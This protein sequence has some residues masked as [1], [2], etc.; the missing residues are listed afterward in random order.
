MSLMYPPSL[1][2]TTYDLS[3]NL[4]YYCSFR[5]NILSVT[6]MRLLTA[7]TICNSSWNKPSLQQIRRA[8]Y[9]LYEVSNDLKHFMPGN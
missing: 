2:C 8:K 5:N 4:S 7:Y 3:H 6:I 9:L 1:N